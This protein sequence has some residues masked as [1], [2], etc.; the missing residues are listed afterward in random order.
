M[1]D[2]IIIV[3]RNRQTRELLATL[4]QKEYLI[5]EAEEMPEAWKWLEEKQSEIAAVLLCIKDMQENEDSV[6]SQ[7]EKRDWFSRI[8][9][10]AYGN[11]EQNALEQK[12]LEHGVAEFLQIPFDARIV[13]LRVHRMINSYDTTLQLEKKVKKQAEVIGKQYK[14]L[15]MQAGELQRINSNIMEIL[16]NVVEYRNLENGE[17]IKSVKKYTE[18]LARRMMK[19][20]P[21]CGLNEKMVR[22]I[23]T[24]STL[25]DIGKIAIPD[26]ILLK[27]GKLTSEEYEYMK[28]HTLRGAEILEKIREVWDGE[29]TRTAYD[30]CRNHHERY[31]GNGYPDGRKEKEIPLA[32]QLVSLAD[33][34]DALVNERVYKE[35]YTKEKA[36]QMIIMG[37]C[38]MF[39][40][41]LLECFR[42]TRQEFEKQVDASRENRGTC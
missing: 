26:S 23:V 11:G 31:D 17:H 42:N 21:E 29:F 34:Y 25:H 3:D 28:S 16:G 30:I 4:F 22:T 27:P 10:A 5:L 13:S 2:K 14:L 32:A 12:C 7:I 37:E 41:K 35:A 6:L 1:R 19:D 40:P 9:V 15:T 33:V 38:G 39:S 36:Y 24:A 20:Y 8:P 18:I